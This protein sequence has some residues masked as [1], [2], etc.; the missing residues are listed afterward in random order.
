[1]DDG[2]GPADFKASRG[3]F[4][5]TIVEFKL[6]RNT[7]LRQNLKHQ[8]EVYKKAADAEHGLKVIL[9]FSGG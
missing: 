2:R 8:V 9:F 6:A 5:K 3:A 7:N 4:D 1:M